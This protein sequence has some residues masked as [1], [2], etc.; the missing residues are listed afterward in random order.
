M[1]SEKLDKLRFGK[2]FRD[3]KIKDSLKKVPE[4]DGVLVS[5]VGD[6][7]YLTLHVDS[8]P[9][10]KLPY[11]WAVS[12]GENFINDAKKAYNDSLN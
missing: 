4:C 10:C 9:V 12:S 11:E 5:V 3:S 2:N 8:K 1:V 7:I 6:E